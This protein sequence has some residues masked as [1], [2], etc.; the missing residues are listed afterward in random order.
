MNIS[1]LLL[2]SLAITC[3]KHDL[4]K[5]I[6]LSTF[7]YD[8]P[9]SCISSNDVNLNGLDVQWIKILKIIPKSS[10]K[11]QN[12]IQSHLKYVLL[13]NEGAMQTQVLSAKI[14]NFAYSF[15]LVNKSHY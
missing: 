4:W 6:D 13:S 8:F 12:S 10:F 9:S 15:L 7:N 14:I 2:H 11:W 3:L 1:L 5:C